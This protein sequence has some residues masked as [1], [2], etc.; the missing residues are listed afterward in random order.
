[1]KFYLRSNALYTDTGKQ[2]LAVLKNGLAG[3]KNVF[4]PNGALALQ[5]AVR[6]Q[7][8]LLLK[9]DGTEVASAQM[10]YAQ[11]DDP[12]VNGWHVHRMPQ[13]EQARFRTQEGEFILAL[14]R[15]VHFR[16]WNAAKKPMAQFTY[17]GWGKGWQVDADDRIP[18]SLL[19][20]VFAFY[21]YLELEN[22]F[23]AI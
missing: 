5:T 1:M 20:A 19:C 16:L 17:R 6:G 8:Y 22:A 11:G 2:P 13:V 10:E 14:K 23:M 18:P 15:G 12:S 7:D 4:L 9:A 3:R 21:Q